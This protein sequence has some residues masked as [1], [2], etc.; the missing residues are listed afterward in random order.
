VGEQPKE[1]GV[2]SVAHAAWTM[3]TNQLLN[4]DEVLNK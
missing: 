3:V 1:Q 2:P 4:L